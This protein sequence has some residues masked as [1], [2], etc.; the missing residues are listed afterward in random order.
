[1]RLSIL[2]VAGTCFLTHR[3]IAGAQNPSP[4]LPISG[5]FS[6]SH[7]S[8]VIVRV[9][10]DAG[11]RLAQGSGFVLQDGR[12]VT[13]AHV[14][15]G[16]ARA[17][18]LTENGQLLLTTHYAEIFDTESDVAIL[19]RIPNP[20]AGLAL[21]NS[22]P[23]IGEQVVVIGSPE[24]LSNSASSGIVG[25]LRQ[26]G[27]KRYLQITAPISH[28]SSGGPVLNQRGEVV[29]V[30][31]MTLTEGQ[32]LNFAVPVSEVRALS[33]SPPARVVFG[34]TMMPAAP[35]NNPDSV[36]AGKQYSVLLA[37]L[38][39]RHGSDAYRLAQASKRRNDF[40][41]AISFLEISDE[42][43]PTDDAK[44][45]LGASAFSIAQSAT[46]DSN[47]RKSCELAQL[48]RDMFVVA[49]AN[50][51]A[52]VRKYPRESQELLTAIP[53]FYPAVGELLKR[54][55]K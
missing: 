55:C 17:D 12:V 38:A 35:R 14:V 52:G 45:L 48:A 8:V 11:D 54:F 24:G 20:P 7:N 31:V 26:I 47:E 44:F 30:S 10:S 5:I 43:D 27:D 19:P 36:L 50:V 33:A 21:A 15:R 39:L 34:N 9:F 16:A 53:Q 42:L 32:N 28:G 23:A 51:S 41:K 1:M 3:E 18:V 40:Q 22:T 6:R 4:P 46:L 13:N 37:R 49:Q 25:A 29:G 2:I